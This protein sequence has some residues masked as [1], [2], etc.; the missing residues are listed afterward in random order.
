MCGVVDACVRACAEGPWCFQVHLPH[1]HYRDVSQKAYSS[2]IQAVV[3]AGITGADLAD[4]RDSDVFASLVPGVPAL[5]AKRCFRSLTTYLESKS[6]DVE[7][8]VV[9]AMPVD[10][11]ADGGV[12]ISEIDRI[13]HSSS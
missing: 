7:S 1:I 6:P 13:D 5:K 12:E 11:D 4:C 2:I 10:V 9:V 8:A 3:K